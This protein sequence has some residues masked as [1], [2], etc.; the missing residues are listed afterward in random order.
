MPIFITGL[1]EYCYNGVAVIRGYAPADVW[2]YD[3][4]FVFN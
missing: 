3:T 2:K 4:N 1:A